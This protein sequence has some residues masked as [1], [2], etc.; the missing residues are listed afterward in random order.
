[1]C[2]GA[3]RR[4]RKQASWSDATVLQA[5]V[6]EQRKC[7]GGGVSVLG[8]VACHEACIDSELFGN[9]VEDALVCL[10]SK[11]QVDVLDRQLPRF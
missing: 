4:E 9:A 5:V 2:T 10:M 6:V 3:E 11:D 1:M 8:D 7:S